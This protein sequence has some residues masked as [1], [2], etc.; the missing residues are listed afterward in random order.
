MNNTNNETLEVKKT[1][2]MI[3]IKIIYLYNDLIFI[4]LQNTNEI[5]AIKPDM[6]YP[7]VRPVDL[8]CLSDLE[9]P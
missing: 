3:L 9:K 5:I 1:E 4:F 8:N 2:V 6:S 7:R